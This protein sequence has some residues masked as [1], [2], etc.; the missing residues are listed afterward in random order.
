MRE[1]VFELIAGNPGYKPESK[2]SSSRLIYR[3]KDD[4]K[5]EEKKRKE[6]KT[7]PEE[8]EAIRQELLK[9]LNSGNIT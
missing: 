4:E 5:Q 7:S 2:P 3:I 1:I 8:L 6:L 9:G